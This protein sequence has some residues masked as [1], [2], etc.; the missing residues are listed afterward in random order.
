MTFWCKARDRDLKNNQYSG[1]PK[2]SFNYGLFENHSDAIYI[3]GLQG[4]I[5]YANP[6]ASDL[7]GY[8]K[9][10]LINRH[11]KEVMNSE[12]LEAFHYYF[13]R[14]VEGETHE[15]ELAM[16]S[17]KRNRILLRVMMVPNEIED[18]P[19]SIAV[20]IREITERK[21]AENDNLET[22][23]GL[24]ESFIENNRDPIL[25]LDL[26]A[27]I[28]LANR[29]FSQL[30]GW[31]KENL[32]G[33]HI[34]DCPSIPPNLVEQ[35]KDYYERVTAA[36][37]SSKL[38][39]DSELAT[40]QTIR[41]TN[42][43]EEHQMLL[44][45]TPIYDQSGSVCNWAVHLRDVTDHKQLEERLERITLA[46]AVSNQL[47]QLEHLQT[48]SQLAASISHEVRNPLT[49]TRGFIQ[50]LRDTVVTEEKK[51]QYISI[52]LAELDRAEHIIT[53]YLSFAKPSLDNV[54]LLELN[55]ELDYIVQVIKP[56]AI[57]GNISVRL[58]KNE[59][60]PIYII[61]EE[62]K[63]HQSLINFIKN[64]IEAMELG[65]ELTIRITEKDD[66]ATIVI[67]DTGKGMNAEQLRKLGTPFYTTKDKGT[68]LGIMVSF[69]IIKAMEGDCEVESEPGKGTCFI[70]SF[71][72][73]PLP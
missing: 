35:M 39:T 15:F 18:Q 10:E 54:E 34:L 67:R 2:V 40:L 28:V 53:D 66:K 24:C 64:G 71:P 31:R 48:V 52:S 60:K 25:L 46:Q 29:A 51:K 37:F 9:I 22:S 73:I 49:V 8:S 41:M 16:N 11:Y 20:Y 45:I 30:L 36:A 65:G 19:V 55:R 59:A 4:D 17:G 12:D 23:R 44:S 6:A 62:K 38:A 61:G 72:V 26:E 32:E 21:K 33:V 58:I 14:A 63:F 68:G 43:G 42:E 27:T 5:V 3:T 47:T 56:Y 13:Q 57:M 69:S 7:F 1:L 50:L 70:I